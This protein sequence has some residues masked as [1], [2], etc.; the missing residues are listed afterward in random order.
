MSS[1]PPPPSPRDGQP[2]RGRDFP[3]TPQGAPEPA[4]RPALPSSLQTRAGPGW[5]LCNRR[6]L[7]PVAEGIEDSKRNPDTQ[8]RATSRATHVQKHP[9]SARGEDH[10]H[11]AGAHAHAW[12]W[13]TG[14]GICRIRPRP[15]P[16]RVPHFVPTW[17][18]CLAHG[19]CEMSR[20]GV[21]GASGGSCA[22]KSL[23]HQDGPHR[24]PLNSS[25]DSGPRRAWGRPTEV[26][27]G[28]RGSRPAPSLWPCRH[29][30]SATPPARD[31]HMVKTTGTLDRSWFS[32]TGQVP[33]CVPVKLSPWPS[34]PADV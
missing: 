14:L 17:G 19:C 15:C 8:G 2:A 28:P 6:C 30:L 22:T 4:Q 23:P 16:S 25:S 29:H 18:R 9:E 20:D 27:G 11:L 34:G 31:K 7:R 21:D 12:G 33:A 3:P 10:V 26:S 1:P 24:L 13:H 32:P 5:E